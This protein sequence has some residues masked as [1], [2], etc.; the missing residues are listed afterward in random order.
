MTLARLLL[1]RDVAAT[2]QSANP[3]L[4]AGEPGFESDQFR[5]RIGNGAL[6]FNALRAFLSVPTGAIAV[7]QALLDATTA[8]AQRTALGITGSTNQINSLGGT[9][10]GG[11]QADWDNIHAAGSGLYVGNATTANRPEDAT[12]VG[13]YLKISG[14]QGQFVGNAI[15]GGAVLPRLWT[16]TYNSGWNAWESPAGFGQKITDWNAV[17]TAGAFWANAAATNGPVVAGQYH[18]YVWGPSATQLSM[19]AIRLDGNNVYF[20]RKSPGWGSWF[21]VTH[22]NNFLSMMQAYFP[23]LPYTSTEQT[24]TSAGLLTLAHGLAAAPSLIQPHIVCKVADA[25]YAIGDKV[26]VTGAE[27]DSPSS[28][29]FDATNCYVRFTSSASCFFIAHKT[30]GVRTGI[31]NASWRLVLKAYP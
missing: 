5:L 15:R 8:A 29:R 26:I 16:R 19:L 31:T 25:G 9:I 27:H 10:L 1:R 18:A 7:A 23:N 2:W 11:V 14:T 24:I 17:D 13:S 3:T 21:E 20:R 6:A 28:I 22:S 30:T 4:S 12:I